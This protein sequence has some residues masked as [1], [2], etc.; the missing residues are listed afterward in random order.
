VLEAIRRIVAETEDGFDD[1]WLRHPL[2][3]DDLLD[4]DDQLRLRSV[5]MG[6]AGVVD[7]LRRLAAKG[8]VELRRDYRPYLERSLGYE[9]DFPDDDS[10]RSVWMGE[11]GIRLVLQRLA[12]TT[13]NL[14]RLAN[15]TDER[16]EL[17]W[18]SP[19]S[20]LAGREL[21]S[22][23]R[24][25]VGWL[26]GERDTDGLWTQRLYGQVRRYL[27]PVH[28]YA[29]CALA[30][31]LSADS[32]SETLGRYAVLENGRCNWPALADI[33]LDGTPDGQIRTQFC[34]GAPGIVATLGSLI[35]DELAVAGGTLTWEA[36]PL[37]KGANLCHGTAG[38]G[39]AFLVLLERSGDELWL[40]RARAFAMH[41][42]AQV[43]AAR[44]THGRGRYSLWTGD[45]GTALYLADCIAAEPHLP[46]P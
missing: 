23:V 41:A 31:G 1:G 7:A 40:E 29:G 43:E 8:T 13:E 24:A 3:R 38:N 20:I 10:E 9:P 44:I 5:Y 42:T 25:C 36:G 45:P 4:R 12:P 14:G 18:G 16:C 35:D 22:D 32:I 27:G 17:M 6:G 33:T 46:L 26:R 34:H 37:R 39:Y 28:G 19:G 21:G 11:A 15:G 2:D 30:A